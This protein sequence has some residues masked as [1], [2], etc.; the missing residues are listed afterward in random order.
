M[1]KQLTVLLLVLVLAVCLFA[2][3]GAK[4]PETAPASSELTTESAKET[5]APAE[6]TTEEITTEPATE[7]PTTE[8]P[9]TEEPTTEAPTTEPVPTTPPPTNPP[10]TNPPP[11][12]P[13]PT[14]PPPTDPPPTNPPPTNPP[15]TEPPLTPRQRAEKLIGQ[16]VSKL[17]E[18][19]GYPLSS[20]YAS[21]C[22]GPGMEDG[23]LYYDG[24]TV[25]T[26]R[27]GDKETIVSV[28]DY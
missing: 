21:S 6:T 26:L 5:T 17:Y 3:C 24:F 25:R 15:P 28:D 23:E 12:N 11:T 10:P 2:G 7:V 9:T 16:P 27:E 18:A 22:Q 19:I 1:R 4:D 20:S 13:P 14:N 8:A